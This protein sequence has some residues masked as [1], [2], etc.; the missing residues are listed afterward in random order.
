MLGQLVTLYFDG[1]L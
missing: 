1:P